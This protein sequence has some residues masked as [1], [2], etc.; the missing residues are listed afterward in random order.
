MGRK[1]IMLV[2]HVD[3]AG[4]ESLL[5]QSLSKFLIH[6][7]VSWL[8]S[9]NKREKRVLYDISSCNTHCFNRFHSTL[10]L[11]HARVSPL[12]SKWE[13]CSQLL[14][15]WTNDLLVNFSLYLGSQI[16]W[17]FFLKKTKQIMPSLIVPSTEIVSCHLMTFGEH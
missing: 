7:C 3:V 6:T 17:V 4:Q 16:F 15:T 14:C 2:K 8:Y 9:Q 1:V 10:I 13:S 12:L 11:V 5:L